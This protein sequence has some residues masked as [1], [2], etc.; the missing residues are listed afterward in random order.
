[1]H[2]CLACCVPRRLHRGLQRLE[3]S[4][5]GCSV[6]KLCRGRVVQRTAHRAGGA[7]L[8][9]LRQNTR[10]LIQKGPVLGGVEPDGFLRSR[11]GCLISTLGLFQRPS[12]L[13]AIFFQGFQLIQGLRAF[14]SQTLTMK[15]LFLLCVQRIGS[16]QGLP[17]GADLLTERIR[18]RRRFVPPAA[19]ALLPGSLLGKGAAQLF[20][21]RCVPGKRFQLRAQA[22]LLGLLVQDTLRSASAPERLRRDS[23]SV[24]SADVCIF[25]RCT[26]ASSAVCFS[27]MLRS[28]ASWDRWACSS[29]LYRGICASSAAIFW[30]SDSCWG[31]VVRC[32]SSFSAAACAA[33]AM[34]SRR[35]WA[36]TSSCR[37]RWTSWALPKSVWIWASD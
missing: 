8:Q 19:K 24:A 29:S 16:C 17:A 2:T 9:K 25:W 14:L 6:G 15:K 30:R 3:L 12:Q 27:R 26:A 5:R 22:L 36:W 28:S 11:G 33:A 34:V 31:R 35:A 10:L 13:R 21:L 23:S 32:R 1:M 4:F 37:A 20:Q 7:V 18:L